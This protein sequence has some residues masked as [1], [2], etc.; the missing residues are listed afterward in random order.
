MNASQCPVCDRQLEA[1]LFVWHLKCPG[2]EYEGSTLE[3]VIN[4]TSAHERIDE[5]KREQ[6]LKTLR[7]Q[8]FHTLLTRIQ[9]FKKRGNRLLEVGSAHGWFLELARPN[10]EVTGIEPDH[11]ILND[12]S[13]KT[14]PVRCGFFPQALDESEKFDVI[15]FNDVIEHIENIKFILEMC[16]RHLNEH[17]V[18]VLNLPNSKGFFYS[19]AKTMAKRSIQGPFN[20]LWQKDFPSP[21]VH[22]FHPA[23]LDA[24]LDQQGFSTRE[25]GRLPTLVTKGLHARISL[26]KGLGALTKSMLYI[27]VLLL[28]PVTRLL[29][30]DIFYIIAERRST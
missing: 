18:L 19:L 1:G 8:N 5:S 3:P 22:Y 4:S 17:G 23:N 9:A 29:P 6:G 30:G 24:L 25:F 21:H 13:D 20:R 12:L 15:V 2:C 14:L 26:A 28:L 11:R 10:F 7:V 16:H 27:V